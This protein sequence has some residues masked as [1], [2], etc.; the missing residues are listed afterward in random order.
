LALLIKAKPLLHWV[1]MHVCD[2]AS[3]PQFLTFTT[4]KVDNVSLSKLHEMY[5]LTA[6]LAILV[7]RAE[8]NIGCTRLLGAL[9]G[10]K[11]T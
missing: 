2:L 5:S 6:I 4:G 3:N 1:L 11:S 8:V 10:E 7:L 9:G